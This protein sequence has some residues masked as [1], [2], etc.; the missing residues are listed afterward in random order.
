VCVSVCSRQR[1]DNPSPLYG[2]LGTINIKGGR[3]GDGAA[4]TPSEPRRRRCGRLALRLP[5]LQSCELLELLCSRW[6]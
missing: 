3:L 2:S 5:L 6:A 1:G 4:T